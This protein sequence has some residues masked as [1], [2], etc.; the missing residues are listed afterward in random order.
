MQESVVV[1]KDIFR[2][3]PNRFETVIPVLCESLD[4]MDEPE[5]KAFVN[6]E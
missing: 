3:Y 5:S 2:K 1:I 4:L 6:S